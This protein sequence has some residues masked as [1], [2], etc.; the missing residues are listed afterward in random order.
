MWMSLV[1]IDSPQP[2]GQDFITHFET[3]LLWWTHILYIYIHWN[4][5]CCEPTCPLLASQFLNLW[6]RFLAIS[7]GHSRLWML[8]WKRYV[9]YL[10]FFTCLSLCVD[11]QLTGLHPIPI[12]DTSQFRATDLH[13]RHKLAIWCLLYIFILLRGFPLAIVWHGLMGW[14]RKKLSPTWHN[15]NPTIPFIPSL[16]QHQCLTN[17]LKDLS[18]TILNESEYKHVSWG[19]PYHGPTK[20]ITDLCHSL[21]IRSL[22]GILLQMY[23]AVWYWTACPGMPISLEHNTC[24]K[25]QNPHR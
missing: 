18:F 15:L 24:I 9:V 17:T 6:T 8:H 14:T 5:I 13:W 20:E 4:S 7:Q 19:T 1:Q 22:V 11:A 21:A 2:I 25:T 16:I 10:H 12:L 23:V 3:L